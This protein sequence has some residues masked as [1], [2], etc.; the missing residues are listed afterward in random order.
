MTAYRF[1]TLT[2]DHCGEIYDGGCDRTVKE[3]LA[4]A[5]RDGWKRVP[6]WK[7]K[8]SYVWRDICGVCNGTHIRIGGYPVPREAR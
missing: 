8:L 6:Q 5:S 4:G 2:C 1:V 7:D 3:A